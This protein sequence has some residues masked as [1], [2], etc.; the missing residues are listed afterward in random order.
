MKKI[1]ILFFIWSGM[2]FAV[3]DWLD[4]HEY[5]EP[6]VLCM[7]NIIF[8]HSI[9]PDINLYY[10]G[11]KVQLDDVDNKKKV[12]IVPYSLS[13]GK[14]TQKIEIVVAVSIGISTDD[15][16]VQYLYVKPGINYKFFTLY[17]DRKYDKNG[18]FQGYAWTVHSSDLPD[19]RKIPKEALI[20]VFD[21]NLVDKLDVRSWRQDNNTRLLPDIIIK[22]TASFN[23]LNRAITLSRLASI[24][25]DTVHKH[26]FEYIK[27]KNS[28]V[29]VAMMAS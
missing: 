18:E 20:F 25:L 12:D 4:I 16:T 5:K 15:N 11:N 22:K 3:A 8:P 1:M 19:N 10:K 27:Q 28:K 9:F 29:A 24:D 7:G 14:T 13:E 2:N 23:D 21:A 6:I 17:A 26:N